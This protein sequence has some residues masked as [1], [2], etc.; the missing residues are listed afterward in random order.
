MRAML[1]ARL[2]TLPAGFEPAEEEVVLDPEDRAA[3]LADFLVS[4]EGRRWREDD[5]AADLVELAIDFGADY[6]H[7]GPLRWSPVVVDIFMTSWLP[8]KVLRERTFFERAPDPLCD[9]V[10]YSGRRRGVPVELVRE[11]AGTV[12]KFRGTMLEA[13]DDR[14]SIERYSDGLVA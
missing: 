10:R 1:D 3:L 13:V 11:A 9:W 8:D 12:A 6:N 5:D 7:G 14:C 2:R 4:A